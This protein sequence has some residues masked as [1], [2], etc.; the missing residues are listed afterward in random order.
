MTRWFLD[1]EFHEDGKTIDLISIAL[2]SDKGDE[3]YAVSTEFDESRCDDWLQSNVL[4][5]LPD[6]QDP[7]WMSRDEI[8]DAIKNLL[9]QDEGEIE[10]WA[11]YADYDWVAFCQLFGKMI[12]LPAFLPMFCLDLKQEMHRRGIPRGR[13]P[14]QA[15]SSHDA[16]ED[17]RWVRDA[18]EFLQNLS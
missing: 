14:L 18:F 9:L 10:I 12:N 2:V 7:T 1:T 8:A 11:Y 15:G 4:C 17:A 3:F 5:Q 16:L 13:L 6:R